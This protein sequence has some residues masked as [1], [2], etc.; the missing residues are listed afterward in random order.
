L[1]VLVSKVLQSQRYELQSGEVVCF[2]F[3]PDKPASSLVEYQL[4]ECTE[5]EVQYCLNQMADFWLGVLHGAMVTD[6]PLTPKT[7]QQATQPVTA[8]DRQTAGGG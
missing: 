4:K 1:E 3:D 5:E 7:Y 8:P 2:E 6:K